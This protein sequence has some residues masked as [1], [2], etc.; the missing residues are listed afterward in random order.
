MADGTDHRFAKPASRGSKLRHQGDESGNKP[1]Y[2]DEMD[3]TE[4]SAHLSQR[5]RMKEEN[6]KPTPASNKLRGETGLIF[7]EPLS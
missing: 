3:H 6:H 4:G 2:S 7:K 5:T 1:E